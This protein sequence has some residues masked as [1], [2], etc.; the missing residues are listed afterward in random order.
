MKI[1]KKQNKYKNKN[2]K[3]KTLK[4]RKSRR[5]Q[6]RRQSKRKS[7]KIKKTK[8]LNKNL[9]KNFF[10]GGNEIQ[11]NDFKNLENSK[12]L[13]NFFE[14]KLLN[15][16]NCR[17]GKE[18]QENKNVRGYIQF[19]IKLDQLNNE[20]KK[21]RPFIFEAESKFQEKYDII[22]LEKLDKDHFLPNTPKKKFIKAF[23]TLIIFGSFLYDIN[24]N[25]NYNIE[26]L[27]NFLKYEKYNEEIKKFISNNYINNLINSKKLI[28]NEYFSYLHEILKKNYPPLIDEI[29]KLDLKNEGMEMFSYSLENFTK[30]KQIIEKYKKQQV[31]NRIELQIFSKISYFFKKLINDEEINALINFFFGV[32]GKKWS[33]SNFSKK[34]ISY[35][36]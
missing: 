31:L 33:L 11:G 8:K 10:Y 6:I 2:S 23:L 15:N 21:V 28:I 36:S 4:S 14:Y 22:F 12:N 26:K 25:L 35:F 18:T 7:R 1:L 5:K 32:F 13:L 34:I 9:R 20:I 16:K 3:K 30:M 24:I 17:G 19:L 27:E 29:H